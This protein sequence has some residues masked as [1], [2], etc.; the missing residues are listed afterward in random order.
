MKSNAHLYLPWSVIAEV[1]STGARLLK[2]KS[3]RPRVPVASAESLDGGCVLYRLHSVRGRSDSGYVARA[4]SMKGVSSAPGV[5][6]K[7]F[8]RK[9]C[10]SGSRRKPL[11][12]IVNFKTGSPSGI[13]N[14]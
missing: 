9:F 7:T 14:K 13:R 11:T 6:C 10:S 1:A 5:K 12:V 8:S 4:V 3:D 2:A